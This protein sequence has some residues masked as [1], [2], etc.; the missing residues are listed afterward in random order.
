MTRLKKNLTREKD[1]IKDYLEQRIK[2]LMAQ[3]EKLKEK[4]KS[5]VEPDEAYDAAYQ[6]LLEENKKLRCDKKV[7]KTLIKI[8]IKFYCFL[9]FERIAQ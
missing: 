7:R 4:M 3:N 2:A 6:K 1:E 5:M 9:G 8:V